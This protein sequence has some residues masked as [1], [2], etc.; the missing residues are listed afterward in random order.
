VLP[1]L[2]NLAEKE[3]LCFAF[4]IKRAF[5]TATG[6]QFAVVE[7]RQV[8]TA[9]IVFTALAPAA[10]VSAVESATAAVSSAE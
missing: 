7:L 9:L 1:L 8:T 3:C 2:V 4:A 6:V 10:A 5:T